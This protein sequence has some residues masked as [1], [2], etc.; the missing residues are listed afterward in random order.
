MEGGEEQDHSQPLANQ[1]VR[2]RELPA[3]P[4]AADA[5]GDLVTFGHG[6]VSRLILL[7]KQ[8]RVFNDCSGLSGIGILAV[9]PRPQKAPCWASAILDSGRP[10]SKPFPFAAGCPS[11]PV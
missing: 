1:E 3:F 4:I 5:S 6:T 11:V 2:R 9:S 7:I 10:V 8:A